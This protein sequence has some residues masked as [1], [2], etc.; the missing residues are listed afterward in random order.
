V[1]AT[2]EDKQQILH[3]TNIKKKIMN[4][5]VAIFCLY[6][7]KIHQ[8]CKFWF[9]LGYCSLLGNGLMAIQI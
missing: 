4:A 9:F 8:L 7:R 2:L 6:D 3:I 1:K 5:H